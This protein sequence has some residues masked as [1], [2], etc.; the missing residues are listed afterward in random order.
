[1]RMR[2]HGHS[3]F[4]FEDSSLTVV[5]DPHDGRSLGIKPPAASADVVLMTHD[6]YDHRASRVISGNHEDIMARNGPFEVKGLS[7]E[8]FST[9]HDGT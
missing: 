9:Y 2:W 8:G 1:M 6:H 4:E 3:C 5:I 7:V